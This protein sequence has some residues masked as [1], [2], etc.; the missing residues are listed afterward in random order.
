MILTNLIWVSGDLNQVVVPL[1]RELQLFPL[2]K[3]V[4]ILHAYKQ[5]FES[6]KDDWS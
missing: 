4:W 6:N 3:K 5:K 1:V 2:T